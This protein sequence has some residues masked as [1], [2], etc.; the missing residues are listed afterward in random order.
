MESDEFCGIGS[1]QLLI[2]QAIAELQVTDDNATAQLFKVISENGKMIGPVQGVAVS[3]QKADNNGSNE[4][5]NKV[6][7]MTNQWRKLYFLYADGGSLE[8]YVEAENIEGFYITL[9]C[10]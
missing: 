8:T 1:C 4:D 6:T 5:Y 7:N 3:H 2:L 9:N 10:H